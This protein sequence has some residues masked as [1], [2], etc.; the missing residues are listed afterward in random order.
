[1]TR[2]PKADVLLRQALFLP[3]RDRLDLAAALIESVDNG[4]VRD[5]VVAAWAFEAKRRLAAIRSGAAKPVPWEDAEKA[6]FDT[7]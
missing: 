6:I 3:E 7:E 1:V 4:G 2:S 5:N